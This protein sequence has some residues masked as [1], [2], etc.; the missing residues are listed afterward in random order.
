M[1]SPLSALTRRE[2]HIIDILFRLGRATAEEVIHAMPG[3]PSYST[4]M[5]LRVLRKGHVR[6]KKRP[7]LRLHARGRALTA[8]SGVASRH[9]HVFDGS[10]E[11]VVAALLGGDASKLTARSSIESPEIVKAL[12]RNRGFSRWQVEE[13]RVTMSC[14]WTAR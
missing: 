9:R 2:R 7:A 13:G 11:K 3:Q 14:C 6:T 12:L 1:T 5:Q 4:R 10:V 8:R